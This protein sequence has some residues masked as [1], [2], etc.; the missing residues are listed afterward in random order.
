M[1]EVYFWSSWIIIQR[2]TAG[3]CADNK[4]LC[5][6]QVKVEHLYHSLYLQG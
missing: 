3:Q 4:R 6:A 2:L 5:I 1:E